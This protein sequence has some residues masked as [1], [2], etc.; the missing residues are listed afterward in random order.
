MEFNTKL[1]KL[2]A[3]RKVIETRKRLNKIVQSPFEINNTLKTVYQNNVVDNNKKYI[4]T[5]QDYCRN[6]VTINIDFISNMKYF[7]KGA[8]TIFIH[9]CKNI[10]FNSNVIKFTEKDIIDEYSISV[11]TFYNGLNILYNF[12]VIKATTRKSVYIINHNIIFK[13]SI[14]DFIKEYNK[15][16]ENVDVI[17]N[18]Y[19]GSLREFY[20]LT[21]NE[22][23]VLL[24]INSIYNKT[25]TYF[26]VNSIFYNDCEDKTKVPISSIKSVLYSLK[27]KGFISNYKDKHNNII[28][29]CYVIK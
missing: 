8:N 21:N 5:R 12:D 19:L 25:E 22:K 28:K 29:G 24:Y 6:F 26:I 13:G 18:V 1:S 11:E 4:I 17:I 23:N 27:K 10:D 2:I 14:G 9:I 7:D 16:Y 3:R 15:Y 20:D